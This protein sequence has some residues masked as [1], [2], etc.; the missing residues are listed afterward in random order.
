M[1]RKILFYSSIV[2]LIILN[3]LLDINIDNYINILNECFNKSIVITR[4]NYAFIC[5]I[6]AFISLLIIV[7]I[8]LVIYSRN[9]E[10]KGIN[11]KT[12]D[13]TF[14]TANWLNDNDIDNILGRNNV[15]G[16]I[17]GKKNKDIIK[18]PFKS[19]FNKNIAVFGSSGSMKTI[20]IFSYKSVR[21]HEI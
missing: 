4:F 15:P 16:L 8:K 17:L 13:G 11:L 9:D 7:V 10:I 20:R 1:T 14:G 19:Y 3:I 2:F 5:S 18:L 6:I 12:D 21:T